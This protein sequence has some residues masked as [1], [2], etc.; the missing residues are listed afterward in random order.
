MRITIFFLLQI[1]SIHYRNDPLFAPNQR[2]T[3]IENNLPD[4]IQI[5]NLLS[6]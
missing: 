3:I 2:L 5:L 6:F 4:Q 1:Y